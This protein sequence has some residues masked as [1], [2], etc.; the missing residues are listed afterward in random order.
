[1]EPSREVP[2]RSQVQAKEEANRMEWSREVPDFLGRSSQGKFSRI[3]QSKQMA[4]FT[5]LFVYFRLLGYTL[6]LAPKVVL[7]PLG[8]MTAHIYP[9]PGVVF[10]SPLTSRLCSQLQELQELPTCPL[11]M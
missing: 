8:A 10:T 4:W 11:R 9:G 6:K 1:M 7:M 5:T 3:L 2:G